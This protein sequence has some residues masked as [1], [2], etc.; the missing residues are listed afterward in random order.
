MSDKKTENLIENDAGSFSRRILFWS[1]GMFFS[2]L[3]IISGLLMFV[4]SE[5]DLYYTMNLNSSLSLIDHLYSDRTNGISLVNKARDAV[6]DELDRFSGYLEP[7]LFGRVTE[8]FSGSYGGIGITVVKHDRG[9]LIMSVRE[10]GPAGN[11]GILTGDIIIRAD[12]VNLENIG[13]YQATFLLRGD[14]GT[15]VGV[16]IA[17]NNFADSLE[18]RLIREKL[19]LIH[20]PYAGITEKKSLYIRILD[21]ESGLFEELKHILDSVYTKNKEIINGIILDLRGNPG[22]LL[23][24]AVDVSDLFLEKGH[25]IVGVKGRSIWNRKEYFSTGDDIFEGLPT[26]V[27]IDRGSA[28]AAEILGGALKYANRAVLIGDTT[29]GKGLVQQYRGFTDGS[30]IRLTTS[31]YYFEGG[32]FLNNPQAEIIDSATGIPP[33]YYY[34][35]EEREPFPMYLESTGLLRNFAVEHVDEILASQ[36]FTSDFPIWYKLFKKYAE[37]NDFNYYSHF[38]ILSKFLRDE[39]VYAN[40]SDKTFKAIDN[41]CRLAENDDLNQFEV[42]RDYIK[43]RLYQI[44]LELKSG[45]EAAYREAIVPYRSE[46]ILAEEI[47]YSRDGN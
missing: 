20:I 7:S 9:L 30:G 36:P 28:S 22:G 31:R 25:L 13:S 21:F 3:V 12:T 5:Q 45:T 27:L 10:D 47:M 19:R 1:L 29:F 16:V 41:I 35:S 43:R 2:M 44:A 4:L 39:I 15:E 37:A 34:R 6:F 24:E 33:D 40:Y 32:V 18:F 42:Y 23:T 14:V 11:A 17:R 46:I 8:E 38:A 26:A